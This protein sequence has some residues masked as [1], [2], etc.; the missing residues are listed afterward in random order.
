M[1]HAYDAANAIEA[2]MLAD[3]LKQEGIEAYIRG[4]FLQGAVGEVPAAGLVRLE[5]AD[6]DLPRAKAIISGWEA[7][8]PQDAPSAAQARQSSKFLP[9]LMVGVVVGMVACYA[10]LRAPV[11]SDGFDHNGDGILDDRWVQSA[12]DSPLRLESDRNLDGKVDL[13]NLY[14][15]KG[16][17]DSSESDDNFDGTVETRIRYVQGN[18][19]VWEVDTNADGF[20][21]LVMHLTH[22]VLSSQ[23]HVDA[24]TGKILRTDHFT[25]GKL[26]S[27]HVD[28]DMDGK[29]DTTHVYGP[30]GDIMSSQTVAAD[31]QQSKQLPVE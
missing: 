23:D 6:A 3:L 16:L 22:G 5:V 7:A 1:K 26:V 21:D 13:I 24:S 29:F 4:E 17:V 27:A 25:L 19:K 10:F 8:Q 31:P 9:G 15:R 28:T 20:F 2:H 14:D 30:L 18:P 11:Q 12:S